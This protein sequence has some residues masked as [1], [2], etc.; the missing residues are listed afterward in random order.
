MKRRASAHFRLKNG[1]V[2]RLT[3]ST[4]IGQRVSQVLIILT[5]GRPLVTRIVNF[6]KIALSLILVVVSNP[7]PQLPT[8]R[9]LIDRLRLCSQ[10]FLSSMRFFYRPDFVQ[11][12]RRSTF[13]SLS[14]KFSPVLQVSECP[15]LQQA[16]CD[17]FLHDKAVLVRSLQ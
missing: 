9:V 8:Y 6:V 17:L 16:T 14:P 5:G 3:Q 15:L 2:E 13:E 1:M 7:L 10:F 4:I 11:G 12:P